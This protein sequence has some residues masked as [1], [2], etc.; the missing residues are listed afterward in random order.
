M[1]ID[2]GT[3]AAGVVVNATGLRGDEIAAL[4]GN[5]LPLVAIQLQHLATEAIPEIADLETEIPVLGG[6]DGSF[7]LR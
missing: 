5:Y 2:K 7:Y 4:A 3:I 6:L 1:E